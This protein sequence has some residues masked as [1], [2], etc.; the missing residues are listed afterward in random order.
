M[1]SQINPKGNL[2]MDCLQ[3]VYNNISFPGVIPIRDPPDQKTS[4][5]SITMTFPYVGPRTDFQ[6]IHSGRNNPIELS[7][8]L[9]F[10]VRSIREL[11]CSRVWVI[12]STKFLCSLVYWELHCDWR[13]THNSKSTVI[14]KSLKHFQNRY[15]RLA[16]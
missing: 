7:G 11:F 2:Y 12:I 3:K 13:S 14:T 5:A 16:K 9:R 10:F 6:L 15:T 8:I 1:V 4:K